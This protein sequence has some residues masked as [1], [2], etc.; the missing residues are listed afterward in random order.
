M[1]A[2]PTDD[3]ELDGYHFQK[4]SKL[5]LL[6]RAA[7]L[8][9]Q[10][11]SDSAAMRPERWLETNISSCPVHKQEAFMPFGSGPRLCPGKNLALLEM[12]MV[13]SM[14]SKN[15]DMEL[16]TPDI[17]VRENIAFT[18]MPDEFDIRLKFR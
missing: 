16:T 8:S 10:Y 1:L 4:G 12:K 9:E 5:V 3:I 11:F 18:M 7:A 2:E 15:F 14:L 17:E 13:L 6:T